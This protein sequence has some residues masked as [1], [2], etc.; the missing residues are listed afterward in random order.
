MQ[1]GKLWW[2]FRLRTCVL[3][4]FIFSVTLLVV[5]LL[6]YSS[7]WWWKILWSYFCYANSAYEIILPQFLVL[8]VYVT[9]L[10]TQLILLLVY[11]P[12]LFWMPPLSNSFSMKLTLISLASSP[13]LL[14]S[15]ITKACLKVSFR[16]C[17]GKVV[18]LYLTQ[19]SKTM[20]LCPS[21]PDFQKFLRETRLYVP[22]HTQAFG[23]NPWGSNEY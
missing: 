5:V 2:P 1:M 13:F 21:F 7:R 19:S 17:G 14:L 9:I 11:L 20:T 6:C 3:L 15:F 18:L 4:V 8:S 12:S 23:K 10:P 16:I 22:S